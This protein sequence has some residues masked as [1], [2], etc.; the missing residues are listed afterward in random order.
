ME[1]MRLSIEQQ[2]AQLRQIVAVVR[3]LERQLYH[4]ETSGQED[5]TKRKEI[6]EEME[7]YKAKQLEVADQ[8][9][10]HISCYKQR[11]VETTL[12]VVKKPEEDVLAAVARRFEV[13][14]EDCIWR[15]TESDGQISLA[16]IQIRNYL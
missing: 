6:Q 2:Q 13:C 11:Q 1:Q 16:E 14:F 3:S 5:E 15:L 7:E 10:I 8:L 9:A 12:A 4:M